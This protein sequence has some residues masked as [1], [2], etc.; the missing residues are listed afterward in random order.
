M[1]KIKITELTEEY[2]KDFLEE[3]GL[4]LWDIKYVKEGQDKF[5][6]VYIDKKE[7]GQYIGTEDCEKTSR[8]L[9][10]KLDQEDPVEESY[11]LEVSSPGMDRELS[12][13]E[14]FEK[15]TGEIID[16]KLY[17]AIDGQ[18]KFSGKL[19]GIEDNR[20]NLETDEGEKSFDRDQVA[21]ASLAVIF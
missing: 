21:K 13:P 5:L 10:E 11:Y 2:L 16:I 9:N 18:K 17:K 19:L 20:I 3:N 8:F 14:H 15:S 12:K 4:E 1:A 6:R 7:K